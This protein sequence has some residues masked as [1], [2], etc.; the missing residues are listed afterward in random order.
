M[1]VFS[2]DGITRVSLYIVWV[3]SS[4]LLWTIS[5]FKWRVSCQ[6]T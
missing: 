6:L 5:M 1:E 4:S 3:T 2:S